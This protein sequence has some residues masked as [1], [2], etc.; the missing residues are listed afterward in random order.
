M[1]RTSLSD[2]LTKRNAWGD[3]TDAAFQEY[4]AREHLDDGMPVVELHRNHGIP[5]SAVRKWIARYREAGRAGLEAD[6]A[7]AKER[8]RAREAKL[9]KK[10]ATPEEIAELG[11][12]IASGVLATRRAAYAVVKKRRL[13]ALV[14]AIVE[15]VRSRQAGYSVQDE[16][17]LRAALR[18][19]EALHELRTSKLPILAGYRTWW[20]RL[21]RDAGCDV[22]DDGYELAGKRHSLR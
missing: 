8:A 15:Q 6:A 17:E 2:D 7:V 4:V 12:Q 5:L 21:F 11:A 1:S 19:K 10:G 13:V 16:L 9:A 20:A 3:A 22:Q 18:A 14:P